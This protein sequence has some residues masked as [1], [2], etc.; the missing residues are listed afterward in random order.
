M[1]IRDSCQNVKISLSL[2]GGY[3]YEYV[4][5]ASTPN[6]GTQNIT[7]P[8]GVCSNTSRI[9]VEAVGNIFFDISNTNFTIENSTVPV[10]A[11]M[12][13]LDGTNDQIEI[14]ST[15]MAVSYTHLDVYKRQE[16]ILYVAAFAPEIFE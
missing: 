10:K 4:L 12:L 3:N 7:L 8:S 14:Q 11:E 2:D 13:T 6:D 16:V 5:A 9:K 15:T 1:C